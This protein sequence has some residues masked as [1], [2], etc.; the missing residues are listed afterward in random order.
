M[1]E[2]ECLSAARGD[3]LKWRNSD[4]RESSPTMRLAKNMRR[5]KPS[6]SAFEYARKR[7]CLREA[8]SAGTAMR[9]IRLCTSGGT[10]CLGAGIPTFFQGVPAN[11]LKRMLREN[12]EKLLTVMSRAPTL[13]LQH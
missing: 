9:R 10:I 12:V 8:P 5:M 11:Q 3:A 7:L 1:S 2:G 13:E 4:S 6:L